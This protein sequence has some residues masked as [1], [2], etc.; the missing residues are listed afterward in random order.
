MAVR[1]TDLPAHGLGEPSPQNVSD[2]EGCVRDF[3]L[4]GPWLAADREP[5]SERPAMTDCGS[6]SF[7]VIP[8]TFAPFLL[9]LYQR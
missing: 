5:R 3:T 9:K 2:R 8:T 6:P 4:P 1:L 7:M